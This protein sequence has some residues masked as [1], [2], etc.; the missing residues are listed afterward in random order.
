MAERTVLA[1][2]G[3]I[4]T[5]EITVKDKDK[6]AQK[7]TFDFAKDA[8]S[9]VAHLASASPDLQDL[10]YK[11]AIYAA[12]LKARAAIREA[13]AGETT[14]L[15]RGKKV[16]DLMTLTIEKVCAAINAEYTNVAI[17]GGE[18]RKAVINTRRKLLE[19]KKIVE[20]GGAVV[21]MPSR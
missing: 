18:P 5:F 4:A 21:P 9:F 14:S 17:L 13:V 6:P 3:N 15:R 12:D 19:L 8:T 16:I 11:H 7:T 1:T 20:K 2:H 10:W